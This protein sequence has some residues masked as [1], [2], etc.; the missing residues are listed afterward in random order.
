MTSCDFLDFVHPY[1]SNGRSLMNNEYY[2]DS[3]QRVLQNDTDFEG[4]D[5]G[6]TVTASTPAGLVPTDYLA[7]LADSQVANMSGTVSA[8][9]AGNNSIASAGTNGSA[10]STTVKVPTN[11]STSSQKAPSNSGTG[12]SAAAAGTLDE[13]E[14][15]N[16]TDSQMITDDIVE[17]TPSFGNTGNMGKSNASDYESPVALQGTAGLFCAADDDSIYN[18]WKGTFIDS[19]N[20]INEESA[21]DESEDIARNGVSPVRCV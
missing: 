7:Q 21:H 16:I 14:D 17:S 1:K 5:L 3:V 9:T 6:E 20:A 12:D 8:N 15:T 11:S 4:L 2:V 19:E 13:M 18:V 10:F